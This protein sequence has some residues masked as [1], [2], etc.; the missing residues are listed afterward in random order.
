MANKVS[1]RLGVLRRVRRHLTSDTCKM[2]YNS[3]VLPIFDYCD[4]VIANINASH[5]NRLQRLQ[6]RAAKIILGHAVDDVNDC[7]LKW[8]NV[9]QRHDLHTVTLVYKMKHGLAPEYLDNLLENVSDIS[10]YQ[11][12]SS[13]NGDLSVPLVKLKT[14]QRTFGYRA[15]KLW[16][17]L[18]L[19]IRGSTSL[20]A[21]KSAC[22]GFIVQS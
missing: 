8:L 13:T 18:P 19:N 11:T 3:L 14:K 10:N 12:R 22:T 15:T 9:K 21:F 5:L 4:V 17:S 2:L 7:I 6:E 1:Q 16:N 20:E